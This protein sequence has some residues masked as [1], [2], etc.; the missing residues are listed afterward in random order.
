MPN[1]YYNIK[2]RILEVVKLLNNQKKFNI[3]KIACNFYILSLKLRD[4]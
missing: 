2:N 1:T 4:Y 3:T